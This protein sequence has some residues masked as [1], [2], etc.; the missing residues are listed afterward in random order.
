MG[1]RKTEWLVVAFIAVAVFAVFLPALDNGFVY[2]DSANLV[3]NFNFRGLTP[4]HLRWMFSAFHMGHYQPLAWLTFAVD[5]WFWGMNPRGYHL[6]NVAL[7]ALNAVLVYFLIGALLR[8]TSGVVRLDQPI[9]CRLCCAVGALFFAVHPLRVESVAWVTERRDVLSA[10]FYLATVLTYVGMRESPRRVVRWTLYS[11]CFVFFG[12]SLLSKAWGITLPVVFF[13]LD[14]YPLRRIEW[15]GGWI[16][17]CGKL[18]AEKVPFFLLALLFAVL[19]F[20]AQ[21]QYAM[22]MVRDHG[23]IE[24]IVQAGYGLCF[25]VWKTILPVN[26]SPLYWLPGSFDAGKA[27]YAASLFAALGITVW[28]AVFGRR[29]RWALSA[30]VCYLIIIS[31]VLGFAQSGPQIAADRYTYLACLP[32]AVLLGGGLTRIWD[33]RCRG[34]A[35][36]GAWVSAAAASGVILIALSALT[37]RQTRVWHDDGALWE[38]AV[39]CDPENAV[40]R[41]NRGAIRRGRGDIAGALADYNIAATLDGGYWAAYNNRGIIRQEQGDTAGALAD[42][43]TAIRLNAGYA[44]A[45]SNRGNL[46]KAEGDFAGARADYDAAIRLNPGYALA[47]NN[48]GNLRR[49]LGDV[50]GALADYSAAMRLAPGLAEPYYNRGRLLET[51]GDAGGALDDYDN[52]ILLN[53]SYARAYNNRG[54]IREKRGDLDAALADYRA[55]IRLE[56]RYARGYYNRG[57]LYEKKGDFA[58]AFADYNMAISADA[59][60]AKAYYGRARARERQ[61]NWAAALDDYNSAIRLDPEFAASHINRGMIRQ[62]QGDWNGALADYGKAIQ[63][64]AKNP[65]GYYNRGVLHRARGNL[66]NAAQDF[67]D[68]LTR[69][70]EGW[71]YRA[72]AEQLLAQTRAAMKAP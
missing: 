68:A 14:V 38:H 35:S 22:G 27:K 13:V 32:F 51:Q 8:R 29:R 50:K 19:A 36:L 3:D 11:T 31:P 60:F 55:A 42:Y 37:L 59:G 23:V 67:A 12:L 70:P 62:R 57:V 17:S 5:H 9:G 46:R 26:L 53:P 61:G 44:E 65:R 6:A 52:A 10:C 45:H 33:A 4:S 15:R 16:R 47:Y 66:R 20:L 54:V 39:R 24:R 43:N 64:D 56:P 72:K 21:K 1:E 34:M 58:R 41:N 7:H 69:A 30:W 40:A 49:S 18:L 2:D 25:Y 28:L 48:R 71:P 63:Y